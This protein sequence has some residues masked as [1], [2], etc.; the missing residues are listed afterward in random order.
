MH[1]YIVIII[2]TLNLLLLHYQHVCLQLFIYAPTLYKVWGTRYNV[3]NIHIL[4]FNKSNLSF[5]T[6]RNK[7]I[8][9]YLK[10]RCCK[11]SYIIMDKKLT[12]FTKFDPHEISKH[13]LQQLQ[14]ITDKT[15]KH[16]Y[17]LQLTGHP[18][19]QETH[20]RMH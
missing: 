2:I 17:T 14:T 7:L 18:S 16:K 3:T 12:K 6:L 19:Y 15:I 4:Y 1:L 20:L 13:T 10:T 9:L 8:F 11:Y 5:I